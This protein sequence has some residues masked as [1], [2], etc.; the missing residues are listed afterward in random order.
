[1]LTIRR[2]TIDDVEVLTHMSR[3]FHNFAPHAAMIN[4]TDTELEAAIHALMEH[5][6]VFVADLGGVVVAMLGAIINPIWF[7]PRVKMAHE[8]AWWV[9]EEAR[10][11]RAAILLVKA[12]EAWAKEQ[13]ATVETMSDLM[14]NTTVERML[15][16]MGFQAS[17]RTYAKEL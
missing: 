12:Y 8:L 16:R 17:E 1:M 14:V 5:G 13:G 6:C 7:C 15:T 3:Q 11:S 2:A 9:N 4:A 10:G